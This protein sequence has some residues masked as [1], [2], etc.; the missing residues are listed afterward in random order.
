MTNKELLVEIIEKSGLKKKHIAKTLNLTV[1]GLQKKINND[2]EFKASEIEMLCEL[3]NIK[4]AKMKDA[5]F[6]AKRV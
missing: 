1:A 5:I 6:F 3:L 4:T 2:S